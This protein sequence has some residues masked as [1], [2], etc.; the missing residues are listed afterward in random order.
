MN[1]VFPAYVVVPPAMVPA[2]FN[3]EPGDE[4]PIPTFVFE[5]SH[6]AAPADGVLSTSIE[7]PIAV[8]VQST[9]AAVLS[10]MTPKAELFPEPNPKLPTT[11]LLFNAVPSEPAYVRNEALIAVP[12]SCVPLVVRSSVALG[13]TLLMPI[14]VPL[15]Y[16]MELQIVVAFVKYE[17]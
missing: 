16:M 9:P 5:L 14:D 11:R 7:R 17:M 1:A 3:L 12:P 10:A 15:W 8:V 2:T 6:R 4:V 13:L